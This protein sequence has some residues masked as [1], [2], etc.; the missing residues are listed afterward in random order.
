M[1]NQPIAF[2]GNK[3]PGETMQKETRSTN[4]SV[5]VLL[6]LQL[7]LQGLQA[8]LCVHPPQHLILQLLLRI[9]QAN[10]Q[11]GDRR[12]EKTENKCSKLRKAFQVTIWTE[13]VQFLSLDSRWS[14]VTALSLEG[15]F[16]D[17]TESRE[18]SRLRPATTT[19]FINHVYRKYFLMVFCI[20]AEKKYLLMQRSSLQNLGRDGC[21]LNRW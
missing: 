1:Q 10:V 20:K 14:R 18:S 9:G 19:S 17:K 2:G 5:D 13:K 3:Q 7:L 6:E 15:R 11:L 16:I 8:V 12:G 4:L 21:I